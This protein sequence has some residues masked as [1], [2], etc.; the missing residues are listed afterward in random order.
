MKDMKKFLIASTLVGGLVSLPFAN[1]QAK[2]YWDGMELVPGQIG[3][4]TVLKDTELYKLQGN[5]KTFVKMLKPGTVYRIYNFT[6]D[7]L[8]V[9]GGYYIKRDSRIKYQTPSKAKLSQVK[10]EQLFRNTKLGMTMSQVQKI[11]T[12]K[13]I[14]KDSQSLVYSVTFLGHKADVQYEFTNGK[15]T[16]I[17]YKIYGNEYELA[18]GFTKFYDHV[19]QFL[20]DCYGNKYMDLSE[21]GL[22]IIVFEQD[23]YRVGL[24]TAPEEGLNLSIYQD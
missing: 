22:R 15:L 8:G 16:G 17:Y 4:L 24:S 5:K 3:K 1:A 11:E 13:L 9:G 7:M 6:A 23:D 2:V 18:E 14:R 19:Q 10:R 20:I 21:Q 12:G